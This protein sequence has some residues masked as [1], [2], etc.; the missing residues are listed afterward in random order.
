MVVKRNNREKNR[1]IRHLMANE[2]AYL[3]VGEIYPNMEIYGLTKGQ[4]SIINI[5]ETVLKQTGKADV[6]ISTWTAANAEIKKA[7]QFLKNGN[8]NKLHFIVDR[9]FPTRQPKYY[10]LLMRTFGNIVSLT[11]SHAKFVII[12]NEKWNITIR[13]SMNLNE[14]KRLENFEISDDKTLVDYLLLICDDII[15]KEYNFKEFE[16]LGRDEK[17]YKYKVHPKKSGLFDIDIDLSDLDI[18]DLE[19]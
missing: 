19:I 8:I 6:I 4:Y 14:N 1:E 18:G 7:E 10:E 3:S 11:N 15:G 5:I 12:R 13:T 2:N 16:L 17:Y 9:S